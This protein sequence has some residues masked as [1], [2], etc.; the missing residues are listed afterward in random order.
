M[1]ILTSR[2]LISRKKRKR[3]CV[4]TAFVIVC[5]FMLI[6]E[7]IGNESS[8]V[9]P[10]L[11]TLFLNPITTRKP[12]ARP[13]PNT[14]T[15]YRQTEA[16]L[17]RRRR[18]RLRD[19]APS[20]FEDSSGSH[21]N[22]S[23]EKRTTERENLPKRALLGPP[24][25]KQL[26]LRFLRAG[27]N[28][29]GE[30]WRRYQATLRWRR[31]EGMDTILREPNPYF[32]TIQQNYLHYFHGTGYHGEPVFYEMPAKT[33]L[34]A[35][36]EGGVGLLLL[37]RYYS[38]ITEFQWQYLNRDDKASSIFVV[39]M[40]GIRLTDFVGETREFVVTAALLSAQHYPERGGKVLLINA[41]RWFK[42]IWRLIR[43]VVAKSTLNKIFILRGEE[44]IKRKL[45]ENV[46]LDQ[47][48][49]EY[50][51]TSPIPL[52]ES[53]EEKLLAELVKHNNRLAAQKQ[54]VCSG[55]T[56]DLH[57]ADWPCRFCRWTPARRY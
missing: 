22:K 19:D 42:M 53:R 1:G 24:P 47:I 44:E 17:F 56:N 28:D 6:T 31:D 45:R 51:G 12:P 18:G 20:N 34:K 8:G 23:N 38:F 15:Y 4:R 2:R 41:P 40:E 3:Q 35:L 16:E 30:G 49:R 48:P 5:L 21:H 29:P 9:P 11:S 55:C 10:A 36:R 32:D 37:L 57:S 33:N 39:D 54:A 50:G 13:R 14:D 26:P 52:G 46:P 43:P 27:N 25:P 7:G